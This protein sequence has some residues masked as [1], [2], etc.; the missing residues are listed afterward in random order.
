MSVGEPEPWAVSRPVIDAFAY[1]R[2]FKLG[3]ESG[4]LSV[5]LVAFYW[6][7]RTGG[8]PFLGRLVGACLIALSEVSLLSRDAVSRATWP[9]PRRWCR[10]RWLSCPAG[11]AR[12]WRT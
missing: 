3:Y 5:A 1:V 10:R 9:V 7:F 2:F 8:R 11:I 12:L 4:A 6:W